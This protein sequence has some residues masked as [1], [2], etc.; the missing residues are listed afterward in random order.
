MRAWPDCLASFKSAL[1]KPSV[2]RA[3]LVV[4]RCSHDLCSCG[5]VFRWPDENRQRPHHLGRKAPASV[6]RKADSVRTNTGQHP[7]SFIESGHRHRLRLILARMNQSSLPSIRQFLGV[8]Y[9]DW[10]ARM[11]GALTVP[12]TLLA[13][14]LP[15]DWGYARLIFGVMAGVLFA[16]TVYR[17]WATERERLIAL[18]SHLA[19]RLGLEF[20]P[21]QPKFVS[22][23][24]TQGNFNMLYVRVLARALSP[25][26]KN[27]RG[28]LQRVSQFDGEKYV[29]L[30]DETVQLPWFYENPQSVQSKQL[31]PEVDAFLDV[32][33]FA[34][35]D[36]PLV[37]FGFL[38]AQS[39]TSIRLLK[40]LRER[41]LPFPERNLKL[42]LLIIGDDS[43]N[44]SL[45][46][47]IHRGQPQ[48]DQPQIGWMNGNEIRRDSN[49][50][51]LLREG[52]STV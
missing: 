4:A 47:N 41:I 36:S 11:S 21:N 15:S 37:P 9:R 2:N 7:E 8:I 27:C 28:Y 38:N 14:L 49:V 46:L 29:M 5:E 31:N 30:F 35:R 3:T 44:A 48:W 26:V 22:V 39:A 6:T 33:W 50:G 20:D 13:T 17:V 40:V 32:A 16:V 42:D 43:E 52:D 51:T 25:T 1:S 23:T 10:A 12:F 19:P 24:P 18:E 45:S 34:E